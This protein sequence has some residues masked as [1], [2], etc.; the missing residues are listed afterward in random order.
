[1]HLYLGSL[2]EGK[3]NPLKYSCLENP[4]DRGARWAAVHRVAQSRTRLKRL[5]MHEC[6]GE[7]NGNPLQYSCLE[8]PRDR[9]AW[10]AAI[11]GVAQSRTWL[12]RLSGS[13][14]SSLGSLLCPTNYSC[15]WQSFTFFFSLN[16]LHK[17]QSRHH[18]GIAVVKMIRCCGK[19]DQN[20][21]IV[22]EYAVTGTSDI[23]GY[24]CGLHPGGVAAA[25]WQHPG[26]VGQKT[27][28]RDVMLEIYSHL[29]SVGKGK[30]S[31]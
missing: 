20:E 7:G 2:G 10:W 13:S 4:V 19:N 27:L 29:V 8:N 26:G 15:K 9:G 5:S 14:S 23:W 24:G 6:V 17:A 22:Q 31:V 12:K 28:R 30:L 1:M 21:Q 16:V 25:P 3:G 18:T 11:Y